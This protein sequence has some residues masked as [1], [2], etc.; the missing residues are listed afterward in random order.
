MTDER[1]NELVKKAREK[2]KESSEQIMKELETELNK[3]ETKEAP[4]CECGEDCECGCGPCCEHDCGADSDLTYEEFYTIVN[5]D[6]IDE[7]DMN[8]REIT[9]F[10]D[11]DF[12][13]RGIENSVRV[14]FEAD[15]K[16]EE[17]ILAAVIGCAEIVRHFFKEEDFDI[18][19]EALVADLVLAIGH[20]VAK[21]TLQDLF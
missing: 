12:D 15:A 10:Y 17:V 16:R 20:Y 6:A 8:Y 7:N 13:E 1:F 11:Q 2:M 19:T 14:D 21:K 3:E 5:G 4:Q 9:M 18:D